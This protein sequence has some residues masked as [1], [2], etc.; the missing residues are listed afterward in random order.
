M[1]QRDDVFPP[2]ALS[3]VFT[4]LTGKIIEDTLHPTLVSARISFRHH[5]QIKHASLTV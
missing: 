2:D 3:P 4:T 5:T 1:M